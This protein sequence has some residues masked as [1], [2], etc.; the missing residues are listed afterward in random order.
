MFSMSSEQIG[1]H[2]VEKMVSYLKDIFR[3]TMDMVK[4][5]TPEEI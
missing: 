4:H 5:N 1:G 2:F 3:V